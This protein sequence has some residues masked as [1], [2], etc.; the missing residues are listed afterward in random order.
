MVNKKRKTHW[1]YEKIKKF[2]EHQDNIPW[3]LA[4]KKIYKNRNKL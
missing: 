1:I 4:K 2:D 3:Y